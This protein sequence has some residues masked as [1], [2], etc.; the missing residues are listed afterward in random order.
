MTKPN[1][2]MDLALKHIWYVSFKPK[3]AF[4]GKR[5]HSRITA[6]FTNEAEAKKFAKATVLDTTNVTAGTL[7]PYRPRRTVSAAQ[8]S[9]WL[10][11]A[12]DLDAPNSIGLSPTS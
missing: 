3:K 9:E 7:N 4:P 1:L 2:R 10:Q 6:T 5:V 11:E 8:I 12:D